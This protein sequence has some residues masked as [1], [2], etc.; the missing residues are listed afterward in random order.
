MN[1][2]ESHPLLKCEA[3]P[4]FRAGV[5]PY[6]ST[7]CAGSTPVNVVWKVI[8][9]FWKSPLSERRTAFRKAKL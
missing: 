3:S 5:L 7:S 9:P 1:E 2:E 8:Y 6:G 4:P